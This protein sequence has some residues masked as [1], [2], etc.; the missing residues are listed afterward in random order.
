VTIR[1]PVKTTVK[2]DRSN[3][4][5]SR[6]AAEVAVLLGFKNAGSLWSAVRDGRVPPPDYVI[7]GVKPVRKAFWKISTVKREL[8]RREK[9][10]MATD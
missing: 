1:Q 8:K 3:F 7:A 4:E 5:P 9:N 10:E 2:T 6:N